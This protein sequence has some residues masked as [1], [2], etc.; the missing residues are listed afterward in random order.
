MKRNSIGSI[1][2]TL[3]ALIMVALLM[4]LVCDVSPDTVTVANA[5]ELSTALSN[6]ATSGND[7]HLLCAGYIP[8]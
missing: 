5:E 7:S 3:T 1:W 6:A 2:R 8:N 4:T